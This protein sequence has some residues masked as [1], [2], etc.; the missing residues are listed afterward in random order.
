L[1]NQEILDADTA[2]KL[3]LTCSEPGDDV[4]F[5]EVRRLPG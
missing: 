5:D 4:P 1:G 2:A 3:D